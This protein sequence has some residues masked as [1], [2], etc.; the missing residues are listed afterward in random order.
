M[1]TRDRSAVSLN[2][3]RETRGML[4]NFRERALNYIYRTALALSEGRLESASVSVSSQPNEEDSLTLDLTLTINA[5]WEY[6]K[7]LRREILVKLGEWSQEWSE[8]EKTDYGRRIYFGAYPFKLVKPLEFYRLGISLSETATSEPLQRT[9]V[10]RLYYGLHHEEYS[11]GEAE[12]GYN[13]PQAY[14]SG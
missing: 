3:P 11:Q 5:D 7:K 1:T 14:M 9:V 4:T 6:I 10:S 2:F 13:C 12:D 8:E